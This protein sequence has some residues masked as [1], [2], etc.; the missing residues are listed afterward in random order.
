MRL[1]ALL[2]TLIVVAVPAAAVPPTTPLPDS[3]IMNPG[4]M[5]TVDGTRRINLSC[6]GTGS[7]TVLFDS[8]ASDGTLSW[9]WCRAKSPSSP[10][11]ALTTVPDLVSA[12]RARANSMPKPLLPTFMHS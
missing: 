12:I 2:L 1:L 5:I 3:I 6:L 10:G 8:G 7:P 11:P 4:K 9:R